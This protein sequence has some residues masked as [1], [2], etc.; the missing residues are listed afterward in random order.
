MLRHIVQGMFHR[1][2]FDVHRRADQELPYIQPIECA[3]ERFQFWI[4]SQHTRDWWGRP[5]VPMNAE[6]ASLQAL[7]SPGSVVLDV[8]AHHGFFSV[9]FARWAGPRGHIHAFEASA[10]NALV[11][12][13]NVA[14]NRLT[15][16]TCTYAAV[17]NEPGQIQMN[18]EAVSGHP[19]G[20]PYVPQV[21]LD[22]YCTTVGIE[23]VDLLK[24]DVEGFEGQVLLGSQRILATRPKIALEIHLDDLARFGHSVDTVLALLPRDDYTGEFMI[25]PD[26]ERLSP[27]EGRGSLPAQ[28]VVNVFLRPRA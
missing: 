20:G 9:L 24:I 16:C 3:A 2:G 15:N 14:L 11:L 21:T 4:A 27:W 1:I 7:C 25:R 17:S 8:G 13:A 18:G 5:Q 12:D 22:D 28:G 6:V 19:T 26:W 23:H 10:P